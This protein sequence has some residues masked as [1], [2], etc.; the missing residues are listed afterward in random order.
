MCNQCRGVVVSEETRGKF[1]R[2]RLVSEVMKLY[3]VL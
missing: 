1:N 3:N 2:C